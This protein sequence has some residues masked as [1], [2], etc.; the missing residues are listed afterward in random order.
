M[1]IARLTIT[2]NHVQPSVVRRLEVPFDIKLS[3]LHLVI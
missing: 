1:T 3:H 2:L